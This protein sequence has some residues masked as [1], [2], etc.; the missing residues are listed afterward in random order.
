MTDEQP[1]QDPNAGSAD[2][3]PSPPILPPVAPPVEGGGWVQP[4]P[5]PAPPPVE[6]SGWVQ[7]AQPPAAAPP[8]VAGS[9]WVQPSQPPAAAAGPAWGQ[10]QTPPAAAPPV[11]GSGWVQPAAQPAAAPGPAW[12]QP[13]APMPPPA[14]PAAPA[15][16]AQPQ[17]PVPPPVPPAAPP[18]AGWGQAQPTPGWVQP[19]MAKGPVTILARIAG[20]LLLLIGLFWGVL[21]V[22]A[23]A[24]GAILRDFFDRLGANSG[25]SVN[26]TALGNAVLD[27]AAGVGIVML[28]FAL[29]E[30][31]AGLGIIFGKTWGRILGILY[32]LLFGSL[33]L[34]IISSAL[35]AL[36][37][38]GADTSDGFPIVVF[39]VGMFVAYLY[40]LVILVLRWRG[41]AR[42]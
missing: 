15:G 27:A 38:S 22:G 12:G 35:S 29:F 16:W 1:P 26:G 11:E 19:A 39:V 20:V 23:I 9:G 36:N 34:I 24:G 8:P 14:P 17:A 4:P 5:V 13:Q 2:V 28:F 3:P 31:L 7:P 18:P 33:L 25:D 10:P 6:G 30:V 40:S 42:A 37:N 21:G 32:S 41:A